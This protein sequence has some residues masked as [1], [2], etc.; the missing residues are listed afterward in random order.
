MPV[1]SGSQRMLALGILFAHELWEHVSQHG[2]LERL[3][4]GKAAQS[5]IGQL[6][7]QLFLEGKPPRAVSILLSSIYR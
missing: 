7:S 6:R 1:G 4:Q 3:K 5:L 2:V